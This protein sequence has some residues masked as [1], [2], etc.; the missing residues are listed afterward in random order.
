MSLK[1]PK[2]SIVIPVYNGSNYLAEAIDSALRQTYK[3]IEIVVVN[4]GSRDEGAT[5]KLALSYGD[6][7]QYFSKT[8]GGVATA[9]NYGIEKMTGDY[10]SWLS[11]D[12]LYKENKVEEQVKALTKPNQILYSD[13]TVFSETT[14]YEVKMPP[15]TPAEFKSWITIESKLNGCTLLIPKEAFQKCGNFNPALRTTQDYDLWFRLANDYEFTHVPKSLIKSRHHDAQDSILLADKALVECDDL[16][17]EFVKKLEPSELCFEGLSAPETYKMIARRAFSRGFNR[18]GEETLNRMKNDKNISQAQLSAFNFEVQMDKLKYKSKRGIRKVLGKRVGMIKQVIAK[19]SHRFE[20]KKTISELTSQLDKRFSRV[21]AE[22]LFRGG[23]SRSGEGSDLVQTQVIQKEIPRIIEKYQIDSLI[24]APCG[25]WYWMK[26]TRLGVKKYIGIDIVPDL[27]KLNSEKF[28]SNTT[29][30]T[31]LDITKDKLPQADI[32]FSRDCL[33]HLSLENGQ[34]VIKN[35]KE[36]GAKYLLM[37]T[38]PDVKTNLELEGKNKFWRPLNFERPPYNLPRPI[39][40]INENCT[41]ANG[42]YKSK[43]LGLWKISDIT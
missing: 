31:C 20:D 23:K 28:G 11:H 43:S 21:Y 37:T 25:D 34:K 30:F 13:Y 36:S 26:E 7:I 33:V 16:I 10:F 19:V 12:D 15:I 1:N 5:E 2:V 22:N 8:N 18:A 41:E 42:K 24:D 9:L 6:K 4:D 27:I 14:E 17:T 3:N 38:F 32:I 35:F 29:S 40:L 39:E